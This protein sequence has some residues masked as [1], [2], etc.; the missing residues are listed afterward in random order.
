MFLLASEWKEGKCFICCDSENTEC[1]CLLVKLN[2]AI[3]SIE[4][5]DSK[6]ELLD[7]TKSW[8]SFNPLIFKN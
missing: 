5:V 6:T 2:P 1:L 8:G 4:I 3:S 7:L